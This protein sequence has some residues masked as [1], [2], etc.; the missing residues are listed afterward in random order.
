MDYLDIRNIVSIN[1]TIKYP[2]A[3]SQNFFNYLDQI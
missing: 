1:K 3:L 2:K